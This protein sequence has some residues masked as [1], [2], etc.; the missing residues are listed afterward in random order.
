M[1]FRR[2]NPAEAALG[3]RSTQALTISTSTMALAHLTTIIAATLLNHPL[4]S[5]FSVIATYN[6]VYLRRTA[7]VTLG[8]RR[9]ISIP[10]RH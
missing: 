1:S 9:I 6:V 7:C 5:V 4:Q 2:K 10:C 3:A 8:L